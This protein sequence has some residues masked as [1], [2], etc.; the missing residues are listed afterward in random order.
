MVDHNLLQCKKLFLF[1]LDGT[2]Y[3]GDRLFEG[4][5]E[6]LSAIRARDGQYRFLTNNSSRSVAAYVK[7]LTRLGVAT[8]AADFL[9]SVDALIHYLREHGGEDRRYYV[10]GTESMKSQLRAAGFTAAERREDANALLMGF[11][12]ELTF[13]K[14]E[15]AC[16]LLGQG[17]PYLATNPDW[18]CPTAYGFVPD[19][20]SVCEMLWRAT[21]RRPVVIGKPE[22]LMPQLAMLE[23][24]VSAQE[25][26]LVGDRVYTDIASGANA[27][28][29]TLLVLSGET[30]EEDL[31]TADPQPTF[32]L[33]D[34]AALLNIL[35]SKKGQAMAN[36]IEIHDFSDP[37]LDVYAR[38]TE[39][40]LLN[41]ADPDNALFVAESPLVIG[42][43]LDAGCEPVS[44]L[45]ERQHT[46]GKGREI[47]ARC[48]QD[49][50]VYT[51]DESVLTQLTGF[52]L[53]RGMLCAMR[54]PKLQS[55]EDVCRDARR[56]VVL[57]NVMNPTNIG[58]IF[59]SA[60]ALGMDAVLLTTAGSDPL[61]RR[62]SRVSMGNVFL[63]PWTYLPESGDWTQLLRDLG[64][65]TVAMA[66]RNDSVRLDDPRLAAEEKLAI[67][68]GTEGDGLA[69]S[70][71]AS[72]DYTVKIPMYHG[73]DSLNVAAAS[74]V[75][76]YELGL[77]PLN[78]KED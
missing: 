74:A 76:F 7:K 25:T 11:D 20:G 1:D 5:R 72:C 77:P 54:R 32:V 58:A 28:I 16:I 65:R 40:Q 3:L 24:G 62:A 10:C 4:V 64:F 55:V 45:M 63:I 68:M 50:P 23:A 41:R 53:T 70:T 6:L 27:G 22:P 47:L 67:V 75:A 26:L 34:V 44:F 57:E 30:K 36:I 29:D 69:S 48:C 51:A 52:H 21:S 13:Q 2:L 39:N 8:E 42:R 78:E 15:D 73:V 56:V 14:L 46:Q 71:I 17:I 66:L 43:A 37:A 49:I 33:P 19:C 12:T 59:R 9:T 18:V 61:Y 38:L 35:E 31:P 60:A